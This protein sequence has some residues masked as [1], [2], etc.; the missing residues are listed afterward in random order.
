MSS[1]PETTTNSTQKEKAKT[2]S[3]TNTT[4]SQ[5]QEANQLVQAN[6][7]TQ[8]GT[9]NIGQ[10]ATQNIGQQSSEQA[11]QQQQI[12]AGATNNV[13]TADT[14]NTGSQL[15]QNLGT[16]QST[17][18]TQNLGETS[19]IGQQASTNLGATTG[20]TDSQGL[21]IAQP[22]LQNILDTAGGINTGINP[23]EAS[24]LQ[25]LTNAAQG[26]AAYAPQIQA[27]AQDQFA[28]G[29]Y[30]AGQQGVV[31]AT[32]TATDA[33]NR[34]L[35]G[36]MT[37]ENNPYLQSLLGTITDRV[38]NSVGGQ[39]ANAGRS[40]SGAHAD[41]LARGM[42]QGLADPLFQNYWKERDAQSAAAHDLQGTA[43]AGS[44]EQDRIAAAQLAARGQGANT[45]QSI[46]DPYNTQLSAGAY[47]AQQPL[48]RLGMLSNIATG[49]AGTG[50]STD[51]TGTQAQ[52]GLVNT[53]N[54]GFTNNVG[55]SSDTTNTA[56]L[57]MLDTSNV[58]TSN[59][60][61]AGTSLNYGLTDTAQQGL[62]NTTQAGL[63]NTADAGLTNSTQ[64]GNQLTNSDSSM[65]ATSQSKT[66]GKT[67]GTTAGASTSQ[68]QSDPFQIGVGLLTGVG[69]LLSD[70]RMK[71]DIEQ[72]GATFDG[73]PI[74]RFRY[75]TS[76]LMH[77]GF[78]ADEVEERTPHAVS[79]IGGVKHVNYELA[80]EG[81]LR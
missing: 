47:E 5:D 22:M 60:T 70:R 61:D 57:G 28:G 67:T 56:N 37:G 25:G 23:T 51:T 9:Q 66:K 13:G 32:K 35:N 4:A 1:G 34:V 50:G 19:N 40:F 59:T 43:I 64:A 75:L 10:T 24:A 58:G 39:F 44:T 33:Y 65:D 18:Q 54:Q 15:S 6:Q 63:T 72:I 81:A 74:Y 3:T 69:G 73:L 21:A 29:G 30:G 76:D 38:R 20:H 71:R 68:T 79:E 55:L 16:T 31:D 27:L 36:D 45:L 53:A 7:V 41:A 17:G 49:V 42:S 46:Y 77:V 8:T 80:T 12:N 2:N 11:A 78:M 48:Q 14:T 52:T 26:N 62:V